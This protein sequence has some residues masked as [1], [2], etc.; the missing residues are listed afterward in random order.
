MTVSWGEQPN[1]G[2]SLGITRVVFRED[3]SAEIHYQPGY[4]QEDEMFAQVITTP[5]AVTYVSSA[6]TPVLVQD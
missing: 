1:T 2:Y 6:Y 4:P 3:M 5:S